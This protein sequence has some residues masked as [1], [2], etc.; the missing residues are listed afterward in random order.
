M[1]LPFSADAAGFSTPSPELVDHGGE[2][3]L[4]GRQAVEKAGEALEDGP[5]V[6]AEA[7]PVSAGHSLY[8]IQYKIKKKVR[9]M[10]KNENDQNAGE[11]RGCRRTR[12][13]APGTLKTARNGLRDLRAEFGGPGAAERPGPPPIYCLFRCSGNQRLRQ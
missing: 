4:I 11:A 2:G 7:G 5:Q 6:L 9:K 13:G 1:E 3:R 12:P 10:K 8:I